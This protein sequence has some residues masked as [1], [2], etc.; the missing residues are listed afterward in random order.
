M[1]RNKEL[2]AMDV[3]VVQSAMQ[4][5]GISK[6]SNRSHSQTYQGF[7]AA[8]KD[9]FGFIETLEHDREVFFHFR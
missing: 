5:N 6:Q 8:L 1:K 2:V 7:V 4:T 3:Q 9:G